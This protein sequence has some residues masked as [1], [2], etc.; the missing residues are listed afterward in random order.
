MEIFIPQEIEGN[1]RFPK[2]TI[3]TNVMSKKLN[4]IKPKKRQRPESESL[5]KDGSF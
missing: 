4:Q 3:N 5:F 1:P 2:N